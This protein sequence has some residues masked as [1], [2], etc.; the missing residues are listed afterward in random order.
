MPRRN[1]RKRYKGEGK[2]GFNPNKYIGKAGSAGCSGPSPGIQRVST[3]SRPSSNRHKAH[4]DNKRKRRAREQL[5][6][7]QKDTEKF[8]ARQKPYATH[9]MSPAQ[10]GT[11]APVKLHALAEQSAGTEPIKESAQPVSAPA[12]VTVSSAPVPA[13]APAA[14]YKSTAT[15]Q[16]T[17]HRTTSFFGGIAQWLKRK[18]CPV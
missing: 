12:P 9:L 16:E 18:I 15:A 13:P 5:R 2:L 11:H 4:S 10:V 7:I 17:Q 3:V 14:P 1:N 8:C 6:Q